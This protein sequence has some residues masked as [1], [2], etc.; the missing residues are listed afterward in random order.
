MTLESPLGQ[1]NSY[2]QLSPQA[3]ELLLAR[4]VDSYPNAKANGTAQTIAWSRGDFELTARLLNADKAAS[5]ELAEALILG[6][7]RRW[8]DWV[9]R[10]MAAPGTVFLTVGA[11]HMGG[12]GSLLDELRARGLRVERLQ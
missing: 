5:P 12:P 6:R 8:S 10:R 1:I 2:A 4:I 9:M 11:G 7:N 3:E